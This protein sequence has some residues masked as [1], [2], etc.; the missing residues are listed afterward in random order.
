MPHRRHL[1]P[2]PALLTPP[3][4]HGAP[5]ERAAA[6]T[7]STCTALNRC[8]LRCDLPKPGL[9]AFGM[10]SARTKTHGRATVACQKGGMYPTFDSAAGSGEI[11]VFFGILPYLILRVTWFDS[12]AGPIPVNITHWL[13]RLC[14]SSRKS[15]EHVQHVA[16][17]GIR[18]SG[19]SVPKSC[20]VLLCVRLTYILN[21]VYLA[22]RS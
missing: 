9:A 5:Q 11:P 4:G 6:R 14:L 7:H 16:T 20:P 1:P 15:V 18:L 22:C 21:Q 13:C 17:I 10:D 8:T 19:L 2:P 3:G 12:A